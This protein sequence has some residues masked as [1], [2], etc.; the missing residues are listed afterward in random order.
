MC[1]NPTIVQFQRYYVRFEYGDFG[2]FNP[3]IVQFQLLG[4]WRETRCVRSFNPTIVQFQPYRR[5]SDVHAKSSFNP[6]IVQFQPNRAS[7]WWVDS[8]LFQSYHSPVSTD[9]IISAK[10]RLSEFQSYHSPVSTVCYFY[11]DFASYH[12]SI[13]P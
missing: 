7:N 5:R 13:L 3:T 6:T 10:E 12:V 8:N 9:I 1:F 11:T 2:G 4:H